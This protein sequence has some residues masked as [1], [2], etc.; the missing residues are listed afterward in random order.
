MS[1][2]KYTIHKPKSNSTTN[3]YIY[4][5][6]RAI[7]SAS[8]TGTPWLRNTFVTVLFPVAMPPVIA[9]MN[10]FS[11]KCGSGG[12]CWLWSLEEERMLQ[13]GMDEQRWIGGAQRSCLRA[14][15]NDNTNR[16]RCIWMNSMYL[17]FWMRRRNSSSP[18]WWQREGKAG[19][20]NYYREVW[21]YMFCAALFSIRMRCKPKNVSL[22]S[23][24][25]LVLIKV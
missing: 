4:I 3:I 10:I 25:L 8:T 14:A 6:S 2:I 18:M 17:L 19:G 1:L 21:R 20:R 22:L 12:C 11:G 16:F 7:M 9:T 5:P 15:A 23:L 24:A 13:F